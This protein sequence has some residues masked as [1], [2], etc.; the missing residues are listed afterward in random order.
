[1]QGM[2]ELLKKVNL[3]C[4]KVPALG[5]HSRGAVN[6]IL[7]EPIH[8][9][10]EGMDST[11]KLHANANPESN[12]G[13]QNRVNVSNTATQTMKEVIEVGEDH[14]ISYSENKSEMSLAEYRTL[15]RAAKKNSVL[16]KNTSNVINVVDLVTSDSVAGRN[17]FIGRVSCT[18]SGG[19]KSAS[20]E[21]HSTGSTQL[22][23]GTSSAT[24]YHE[25]FDP[26]K[27]AGPDS[28]AEMKKWHKH[29]RERNR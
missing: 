2:K 20:D 8:S 4:E 5:E 14:I 28:V 11:I 26:F 24:S 3:I 13:A 6:T 22:D 19:G 15:L 16:H 17:G 27:A 9:K 1:M 25:M 12:S 18:S 29:A 23:G 7:E 10:G 21:H